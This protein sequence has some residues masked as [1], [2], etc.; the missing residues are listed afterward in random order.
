M[1]FFSTFL[2]ALVK[3][4]GPEWRTVLAQELEL[5]PRSSIPAVRTLAAASSVDTV[6]SAISGPSRLAPARSMMAGQFL[7]T[8]AD[9]WISC[10]DDATTG[11]EG[12][13]LLIRACRDTQAIVSAPCL[14]RDT[15]RKA[16]DPGIS[17]VRFPPRPPELVHG[18][19]YVLARIHA[20]GFGIVAVHR[21]AVEAMVAAHPEL[22]VEDESTARRFPALFFER[23]ANRR[24]QGE[25]MSF[26]HRA[27]E[28]GLELHAL[29]GV[30]VEHAGRRMV[31]ELDQGGELAMRIFDLAG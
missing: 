2:Y 20:T 7:G 13:R 9:V 30:D 3:Q 17:N 4:H 12:M 28:C 24:W 29:L 11:P 16:D 19:G 22:E 23:I 31:L 25:D 14:Q 8:E 18:D 26:C 27:R 10:D 1:V 6:A 5:G 21:V 15:A